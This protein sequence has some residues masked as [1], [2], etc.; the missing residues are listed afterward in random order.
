L[1][2]E[3]KLFLKIQRIHFTGIGGIGM[4]GI[5]E[6]LHNMG[7]IVTGSD[8]VENNQVRHL[9]S[10]GIEITI[11]HQSQCV[12]GAD[13][14]VTSSAIP[15]DNNEVIE[16]KKRH[17]PVIPR[18]EMLAELMKMK[19]GV[20]IAGAHGKTTTASIC[21]YALTEAGVDPTL[22]IGGVLKNMGSNTKLGAGEFLVAEAD[23][24][25]GTFLMLSPTIAVVTCLDKEHLDFYADFDEIRAA[26]LKFINRVPFYGRGIICI[27]DD[28]LLTL[29][30]DIK[31]NVLTYGF[32]SQADITARNLEQHENISEF[33]V[34]LRE[35]SLGRFRINIPGRHMV[36]NALAAIAVAWELNVDL[37]KIRKAFE[38]FSGVKRRFEHKGTVDNIRVYDDYAHHPTEIK[39]TLSMIK[40]CFS[41]PVTVI[42]QPHRYSRTKELFDDFAR[43]FFNA[44]KLLIA[45]VYAANEKPMQGIDNNSLADLIIKYGHRDA[46]SCTD[47]EEA[48][49]RAVSESK[50]GS[51]IITLGAGSITRAGDVIV[52][53]LEKKNC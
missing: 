7:F 44:D 53:K 17:I 5:A 38:T 35:K 25:D 23:E 1:L 28:E 36:S 34:Y 50:S 40:E 19:Y 45:P 11:P 6:L 13:V 49:E 9:Q 2:K 14:L 21:G 22:I 27:D 46:S 41:C 26:F 47:L 10:L 15:E 30:P 29:M 43:A 48:I 31:R 4:S 42:F 20:A 51:M 8:L 52:K 16:A 39:A 12:Q 24:S 33:D 37:E 18:A 32:R 3:L